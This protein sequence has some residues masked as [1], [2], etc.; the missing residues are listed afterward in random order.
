MCKSAEYPNFTPKGSIEKLEGYEKSD[1]KF[2]GFIRYETT[3]AWD[4][5]CD[6]LLEIT[7]AYEGVEVFL[8]GNSLGIQ[9]TPRYLYDLTPYLQSGRNKLAIEVTTTLERERGGRKCASGIVGQVNLY[10]R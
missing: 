8:N 10:T 2:S 7:D 6:I 3:I 5:N 9:V 1:P 4:E